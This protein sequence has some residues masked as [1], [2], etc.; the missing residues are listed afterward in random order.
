MGF[1]KGSISGTYISMIQELR[2]W[3]I[4]GLGFGGRGGGV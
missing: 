4:G 1:F 3:G 2:F